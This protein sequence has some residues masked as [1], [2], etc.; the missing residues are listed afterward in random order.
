MQTPEG[1]SDLLT[2]KQM[3]ATTFEGEN[4]Q[5]VWKRV[6]G[7]QVLAQSLHAANQT[8]ANDRQVHSL[9]GYFILPGDIKTSSNIKGHKRWRYSHDGDSLSKGKAIFVLAAYIEQEALDQQ[10]A[11]PRSCPEE[12][13]SDA[14]L[15]NTTDDASDYIKLYLCTSSFCL[16]FQ[17]EKT[18]HIKFC[19]Q[20]NE[21]CGLN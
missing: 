6:Y 11:L 17:L 21:T 16:E 18:I 20:K 2:L 19:Q 10:F 13:I 8:V 1:L 15:L 9:H 5:T 4:Y 7:G 12:L 14:E 3:N